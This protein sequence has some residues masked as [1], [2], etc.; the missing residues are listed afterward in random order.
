MACQIGEDDEMQGIGTTNNEHE[1]KQF[2]WY[3]AFAQQNINLIYSLTHAPKWFTQL[4]GFKRNM[5]KILL[6]LLGP[7]PS[8]VLF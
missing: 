4:S 5:E 1:L 3:C 6:I 8:R 7:K 2:A